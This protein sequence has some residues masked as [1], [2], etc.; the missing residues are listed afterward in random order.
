MANVI[1]AYI[2]WLVGG[3]IGLHHF[4]LGRDRQTDRNKAT[5]TDRQKQQKQRGRDGDTEI[6]RG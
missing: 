1:I 5:H 3:G 2:L 6:E 4:Y